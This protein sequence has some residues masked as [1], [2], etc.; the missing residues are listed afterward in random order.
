MM[1][2]NEAKAWA[3]AGGV[4]P[5]LRDDLT[6]DI[7]KSWDELFGMDRE[8]VEAYQLRGARRRL[9]EL[10]PKVR[11]LK[12]QIDGTG[13][14]A[15]RSLTDLL[16]LLFQDSL[17][18]SYPL[19]LIEKNRFGLLTQ[20]LAGL[21][22]VD[23]SAVNVSGCESIDGWIDSVEAQS[24]VQMIHTSGTTG[25]LSFFPRTTLDIRLWYESVLKTHAGFGDEPGCVLGGPQG[26]RMPYVFPS[27]RYGRYVNQRVLRHME[28]DFAPAPD[29]VYTLS[30]GTLSADLVSLSGRIRVAQ[31]KGEL[32]Q[33]KLS[34]PLRM[35]MKQYLDE[36]ERRPVEAAAFFKRMTE[37]LRDQRVF[38]HSPATVLVQAALAGQERGLSQVFASDGVAM[39]GGGGKGT[40]LPGDWLE[41]LRRFTGIPQWRMGYGMS[42]MIGAIPMCPHKRY[43]L[44]PF[45]IPFLLDPQSGAP[46]PR[47]GTATGRVAFLDLLQ[48]T[49]WGGIITG[50]QVTISW[51]D[52]CRCGRKGVYL[53][54]DIS[55][56]SA[57]ITGEDKVTC[58][59]TVDNTDAALHQLLKL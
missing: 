7:G 55:R 37:E 26:A 6:A 18:K 45:Y 11:A 46:L 57:Q 58:A 42:E 44:P 3:V 35:A 14:T 51:D 10:A 13:V 17:Y 5:I 49:S 16:P 56:Y 41:V 50:D 47:E 54:E 20:W 28:R 48:Q 39:T 40:S 52:H 22:S 25:K 2:Q 30:N 12:A 19:S 1:Q 24:S 21:T 43:H 31:A 38:L 32:A 29:E 23:L 53:D 15:L 27:V 9:E 34:E 8:E 36:L 59:A 4:K 33:M